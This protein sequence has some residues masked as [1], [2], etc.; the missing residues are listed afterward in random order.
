ME[1]LHACPPSARRQHL[2]GTWLV[3]AG[4]AVTFRPAQPGHVRVADGALWATFDGP[5]AGPGN[6]RGDHVLQ[7]GDVVALRA[8]ERLVVESSQRAQ[9]ARFEW[10]LAQHD[11]EPAGE[12]GARVIRNPAPP[13]ALGPVLR[14]AVV[15][16]ASTLTAAL[17]IGSASESGRHRADAEFG[18]PP[19]AAPPQR[20]KGPA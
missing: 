4:Q 16:A 12:C 15:L 19:A 10:Q 3:P 14:F 8:G 7:S 17:W 9:P 18:A 11:R 1:Q 20:S 2:A 6:A 13:D 5:H